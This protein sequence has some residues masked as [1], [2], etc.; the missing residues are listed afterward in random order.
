VVVKCTIH[1][2]VAYEHAPLQLKYVRGLAASSIT[3]RNKIFDR[4]HSVVLFS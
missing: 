2:L 3:G 1:D 4:S